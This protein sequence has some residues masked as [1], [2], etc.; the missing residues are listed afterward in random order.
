MA[1]TPALPAAP[2]RRYVARL[3]QTDADLDAAQQ[4]R[5]ESFGLSG[6]DTDAF[7]SRCLHILVEDR[8][9]ARLVCCCRMLPLSSG[10]QIEQSYSAQFYDLGALHS[11]GGP[12]VELGRFCVASGARDPDVLRSAWGAVTAFVDQK[13]VQMLF[14]C[15]SFQGTDAATYRDTFAWLQARHVAPPHLRPRVK[16]PEVHSL[17]D[18]PGGPD[19]RRALRALPSLL[20]TYLIM[21][22]WVSDHA[23]VDRQMNTLHVFTGLEIAAIPPARQRLLRAVASGGISI[24]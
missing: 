7:D 23:V 21:G 15:S 5:G 17:S 14:G 6:Q 12:M 10:T 11:F 22:G 3:A 18:M 9:T 4:L 1:E 8:R 13:G 2:N 24:P 20:R 19:V 16:S